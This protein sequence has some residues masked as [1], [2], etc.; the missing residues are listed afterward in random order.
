MSKTK[1]EQYPNSLMTVS[2]MIADRNF[3][4]TPPLKKAMQINKI[5]RENFYKNKEKFKDN[6]D[7]FLNNLIKVD[8]YITE[9][10]A[11]FDNS[12]N[13]KNK[14][15]DE[16]LLDDQE[17]LFKE[18][19]E[20]K[21]K[22]SADDETAISGAG[23]KKKI[24]KK[25]RGGTRSGDTVDSFQSSTDS[26]HSYGGPTGNSSRVSLSS[27]LNDD[28]YRSLTTAEK[29]ANEAELRRQRAQARVYGTQQPAEDDDTVSN[30]TEEEYSIY[31]PDNPNIRIDPPNL[32]DIRGV[33]FDQFDIIKND[34]SQY[35]FIYIVL[36][37]ILDELSNIN[38]Y[39]KK[40]IFKNYKNISVYDIELINTELI[41][42]YNSWNSLLTL[43]KTF[44][45]IK[46]KKLTDKINV[47]FNKIYGL[48]KQINPSLNINDMQKQ[49]FE[50]SLADNLA[51]EHKIR[52]DVI[53]EQNARNA[54]IVDE[55]PY[56]RE[57]DDA[58]VY[59]I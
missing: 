16:Q 49:Q 38:L 7:E 48:T 12:E 2:R 53:A 21:K 14:K 59:Y 57:S 40:N 17:V 46:V 28:S 11:Y 24:K 34:S 29:K 8:G 50:I 37:K 26:I 43:M 35:T 42:L 4:D 10:S 31:V 22:E 44:N 30:V 47:Q 56:I 54:S 27:S 41:Q 23:I 55:I 19:E 13:L 58:S 20:R 52:K 39:Y 18:I 51:K 9:L 33:D 1:I 25:M 3:K 5:E 6:V 32:D 15:I 45:F 36:T